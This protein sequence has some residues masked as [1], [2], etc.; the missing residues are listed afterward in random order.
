MTANSVADNLKRARRGVGMSGSGSGAPRPVRKSKR[1]GPR[2]WTLLAFALPSLVLLLLI[3]LYPVIYAFIQSLHNG[4]LLD[5]GPFVGLHNYLNILTEPAFWKAAEFTLIFTIV[6]VFG[7]WIVGLLLSL[8]LRTYI[9]ANN[10]FKVLLLLPWIVPVVVSATSWN[11]LVATPQSPL[12]I[13]FAHLG[14][15]N[16]L[17]LA[18]PFLA[19]VVVCVF[20]VW[21]SFPFMMMMMSSALAA[22]DTNVYEAAKVDGSSGFKTFRYITMPMIARTTFVS[23]ILM[24][25]F[26]VNDFPTIFLL[27]GGGPVN[28]TQSL[29]VLAYLTVFQNFQ[30]GPGIAIAFLMTLVLVIISVALY[31][32]IRKVN[33]E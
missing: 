2:T 23:W 12:P 10:L 9:P 16:V 14:F 27:T 5:A 7:S 22:V 11:W 4:T 13:L 31:R 24:T 17:F 30:T 15:G 21:I 1:F 18:D 33:I 28:A 19:Q 25:I 8:L 3:N 6:G 20:K 26:C 32:Q 29:V